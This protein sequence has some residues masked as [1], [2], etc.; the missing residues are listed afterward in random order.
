M[1]Q[2]RDVVVVG[3]S[4]G[5]VESLRALMTVLPV[6][7]PAAVLVVLHMPT[8][9]TSA[10]P[11]ILRRAGQLPVQA[12]SDGE[13][14]RHGHV[15]TSVPDHH[16]LVVDG[17]MT[18]SRGATESGHRPAVDA[19]F[20]SA[21][22]VVGPRAIGVVLS[23]TLDDGT[24]GLMSIVARGGAA[25][26]QAPS[27]AIYPGMPGNALREVPT[28]HVAPLARMGE[29]LAA[30]TRE[31]LD[32]QSPAAMS[33][34][35]LME[36]A[37][38]EHGLDEGGVIMDSI[39]EPSGF[40]CPDCDGSLLTVPH[41]H[42][43]RCRVGHAWTLEALAGQK[44]AEL[45]KALWT[46]LRT[47]DEKISLNRRMEETAVKR[48]SGMLAQRYAASVDEAAHAANILREFLRA[49]VLPQERADVLRQ[50]RTVP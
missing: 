14:L 39:G 7:L 15:Y 28:A 31:P 20:R 3:A 47:L 13:P 38:A 49:D 48:G 25:V 21:A 17:V 29:L 42:R 44:D 32:G 5:G 9:A 23:G 26:V 24:A 10:L 41:T 45:E 40:T 30:L 6:D 34:S 43:Y 16:L 27:D 50:E 18:L 37:I 8:G 11:A 22:R 1:P 4:A 33:R 46:A 36:A 35:D 12:A 2:C 19:L